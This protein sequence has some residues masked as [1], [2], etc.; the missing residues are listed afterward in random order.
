MRKRR[1]AGEDGEAR[2]TKR[3]RLT[4]ENLALL[5]KITRKKG[6]KGTNSTSTSSLLGSTARSATTKTT[7]TTSSGFAIQAQKN[8]ILNQVHSKPPQSLEDRRKCLARSRGTA[9]PPES[10]YERYTST[11]LKACNEATIVFEVGGQLLKTYSDTGYP[12]AYNQAFTAFPR[13]AGFNNAL[14][15]PQ[16]DF[17]EGLEIRE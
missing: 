14:S 4:K 1:I 3:V 12:K 8:G 5:N 15:A 11:V 10:V 13:D 9:S 16:P 6:T 7:S 17:V 2:P